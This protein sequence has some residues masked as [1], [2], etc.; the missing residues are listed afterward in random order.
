MSMISTVFRREL[1]SYFATPVAYVFIVIFLVLSSAF[2]FYLGNFFGRGQAATQCDSLLAL[3]AMGMAAL[4][5]DHGMKLEVE[6]GYAPKWLV[7]GKDAP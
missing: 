6:S 5:V 4:G 1:R 3:P 7:L 2:T